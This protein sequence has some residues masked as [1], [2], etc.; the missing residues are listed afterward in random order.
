MDPKHPMQDLIFYMSGAL[1]ESHVVLMRNLVHRMAEEQNWTIEAPVFIDETEE[2]DTS[3]VDDVPIR[4][5]GAVLRIYSGLPPWDATL[6]K[7]VD[8][9]LFNEVSFVV[10]EIAGLSKS[11]GL[12]FAAELDGE[13]VGWIENGILNKMLRDGLLEPWRRSLS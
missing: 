13:A 6:P 9:A 3:N 8:R 11:A 10:R 2:P 7:E 12:E 4:T 5:V 1:D